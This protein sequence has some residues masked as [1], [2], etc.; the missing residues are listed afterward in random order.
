MLAILSCGVHIQF[1][2]SEIRWL[3][4][5]V[6]YASKAYNQECGMSSCGTLNPL[7]QL[8]KNPHLFLLTVMYFI[9]PAFPLP[10][11]EGMSVWMRVLGWMWLMWWTSVLVDWVNVS[12]VRVSMGH[13]HNEP[14]GLIQGFGCWRGVCLSGSQVL[15]YSG[16]CVTPLRE[17]QFQIG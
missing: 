3:L 8:N 10:P 9:T 15:W 7:P 12:E 16:W 5:C 11:I 17:I 6:L 14:I 13:M 2:N 1:W 4:S